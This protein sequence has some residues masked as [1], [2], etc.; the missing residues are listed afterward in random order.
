M[1]DVRTAYEWEP[2]AV[3]DVPDAAILGTEAPLWS[4]TTRTIDDVELLVFPRAAAEAEI[5]WSPQHGKGREWSS[6]RERLGALA[7]LW[8]A[9]GTRFHPVADIPWSD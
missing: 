4:E 1:I 3:L 5:A 6:F 9:E 7:P 2:T 8:K